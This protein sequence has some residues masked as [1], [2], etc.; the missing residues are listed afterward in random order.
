M[1]F[2]RRVSTDLGTVILHWVLV[3]FFSAAAA[4]GLRIASDDPGLRW[5]SLLD[6]ILPANGLWL[7]HMVAAVGLIAALIAY[8][9]YMVRSRLVPRVS[10][11]AAQ[12][13]NLLVRGRMR[14]AAAG[15][16]AYWLFVPAM[17][18]EI[19]T[20]F[21]LFLGFGGASLDLHVLGAWICLA[22][23][24]VH[25]ACHWAYGR[26]QQLLRVL[27]P[28]RLVVP[29]PQ[30]DFAQLLAVEI[31]KSSAKRGGSR[32]QSL[33]HEPTSEKR[34]PLIWSLAAAVVV[35]IALVAVEPLTRQTLTVI[36]IAP[37][38]APRLNG[39]LSDPAWAYAP[40][41]SVLTEH[42]ANFGGTGESLVEV[43]AVHDGT[44][45]YFAFTWTD[46]TRSLK[47]LPLVKRN[48]GWHLAETAYDHAEEE[49]F[50]EDKFAV[51]V[52]RPALP[53]IGAGIH[54]AV[55]PLVGLPGGWTGRGLHYL[56][57]GGLANVWQWHSD[58]DDIIDDGAFT[59]PEPASPEQI[60]GLERY[61]GGYTAERGPA[62]YIDNFEKPPADLSKQIV[63]PRRLP[64]DA[65]ALSMDLG[66]ISGNPDLSESESAHWWMTLEDSVPYSPA[67][68]RKIPLNTVI[69][70]V[71]VLKSGTRPSRIV[72]A[73]RWSAGR[74]TLTLARRMKPAG[75]SDVPMESGTMLWVAAFDHSQTRHTR[76]LRPI[77]LEIADADPT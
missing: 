26:S 52:T 48:D 3:A 46:P 12:F 57:N 41:V 65:S 72:G 29:A 16:I 74:W 17:V 33:A 28:A 22:F 63:L 4:S 43:R 5:L 31:G 30:P 15:K 70:G 67:A 37:S 35:A 38:A 19:I 20:G 59:A 23:P 9:V 77:T 25:I 21:V 51:L 62:R 36:R 32:R 71:V 2:R 50:F 58:H 69:P 49:T 75:T 34:R 13:A 27:R 40:V 1:S 60:A 64:K 7:T 54:L 10:L 14:W 53:L 45:I 6:A 8:A 42:G 68:D 66:W 56:A 44:N 73:A 18:L 61:N 24:L 76:H 11:G 39:D 55:R 47:H